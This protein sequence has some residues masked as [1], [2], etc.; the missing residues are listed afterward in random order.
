MRISNR[1]KSLQLFIQYC[2]LVLPRNHIA[3]N[4][5]LFRFFLFAFLIPF[6]L[7]ALYIYIYI[8]RYNPYSLILILSLIFLFTSLSPSLFIINFLQSSELGI[9]RRMGIYIYTHTRRHIHVYVYW[10]LRKRESEW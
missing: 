8:S 6:S 5:S 1:T 10:E 2:S 4:Y 7:F 3:F 9:Y